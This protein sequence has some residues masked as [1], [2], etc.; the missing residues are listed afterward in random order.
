MGEDDI[1]VRC[2]ETRKGALEAFNNVLLRETPS[3]R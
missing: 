1:N 3:N 2:L